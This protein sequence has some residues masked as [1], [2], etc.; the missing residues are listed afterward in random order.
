MLSIKGYVLEKPRVGTTNAAFTATP[1]N[2]VSDA[3]AYGT[4]YPPGETNPRT[5]YLVLVAQQGDLPT[6][7]FAWTKNEVIQRFDYSGNG[8]RFQTLPGGPPTQVGLIGPSVNTTRLKALLPPVLPTIEYPIRVA[9]TGVAAGVGL[10][11]TTVAT[12]TGFT[13]PSG[14][15][16]LSCQVSR[17]TGEFNFSADV[18][19]GYV[20][21]PVRYWRNQFFQYRES[22]G[23]I[24]V[25]GDFLLLNPIPGLGAGSSQQVPLVRIGFR[26]YL[27]A[28]SVADDASFGAAPSAGSFKWSIESGTIHL[29][30]ADLAAYAGD[31][32]YYD[33][34]CYQWGIPMPSDPAGTVGTVG[35]PIALT[36]MPS[37]GGDLIFRIPSIGYQF[38]ETVRVPVGM[39]DA[40]G[41]KGQVQTDKLGNIQFSLVDRTLYSA[42]QVEVIRGDLPIDHGI[43]LRLFRTPVDPGGTASDTRDVTALHG[44]QDSVLADPIIAS[45]TVIFPT[46][47]LDDGVLAVSVTQGT[48]SFTGTLPRLDVSS[49]PAGVGYIMDF[50]SRQLQFGFRRNLELFAVP[51]QTGSLQLSSGLVQT[52]V[53]LEY[54]T[55]TATNS[56]LP[57]VIGEDA[58]LDGPSG[59]LQWVESFGATREES[60]TGALTGVTFTDVE[61]DFVSASVQV[62]D[63][64][65]VQSAPSTGLY[66]VASIDSPTQVTVAATGVTGSSLIYKIHAGSDTLVD[67]FFR[68]LSVSDPSTKVE[69]IRGLRDSGGALKPTANS[70]RLS[71]KPSDA[72]RVRIRF[73]TARFSTLV[74]VVANDGLFTSPGSLL[75]GQVEVSLQTGNLNFSSADVT[76][77]EGVFSVLRLAE[78]EYKIRPQP[79]LIQ[80]TERLLGQDELLIGYTGQAGV[81]S[82]RAA[83]LVRKE[84]T[85]HPT[86]TTVV[87]FNPLGR[88][89]ATQPA[90]A[91]FRGG[92]PQRA[93]FCLVD[94][95]LSTIRFL[96]DG[97][98]TNVTAHGPTVSPQERIT[99][100]YYVY[101]ALGGENTLTVLSPPMVIQQ[102]IIVSGG[103]I[104]TLPGNRT[105]DLP[106]DFLFRFEG[107]EVYRITGSS[108]SAG[109]TTINVGSPFRTDAVGPR[110]YV[111]SG[112]CTTGAFF[113]LEAGIRY[114]VSRGMNVIPL[115]GDQ[116]VR[117]PQGTIVQFV[118]G[119]EDLYL[120]SGSTYDIGTDTTKVTLTSTVSR[121]YLPTVTMR[122]SVRPLYEEG[123]KIVSTSKAPATS[124]LIVFRAQT[125]QPGQIL[126][127][128]IDYTA[129]PSGRITLSQPLSSNEEVGA[130]YVGAR[131]ISAGPRVRA[132][133][134]SIIAPNGSNG[135]E[136]Q[137]LTANFNVYSPDTF[138]WR[139]ESMTKFRAEIASQFDQDVKSALPTTGPVTSN[140]S[141]PK[142]YQQG[143]ESLYF[144][145]G[146]LANEDIIGRAFLKYFNDN[147]N[148]LEDTLASIDGRV[149]GD[150]DG[151][152]RYDGL[153]GNTART[154]WAAVTN[155]IDDSI[156]ISDA[157]YQITFFPMVFTSVGTYV[158]AY[159]P[160]PLSRF[161]PTYKNRFGVTFA[162]VD[163]VAALGDPVLDTGSK[164][165]ILVDNLRRR[166]P[167][168]RITVKADAGATSLTVDNA[169]GSVDLLRPP[170]ENG[171]LVI[172]TGQ[173]GIPYVLDGSPLTVTS[174][175][176]TVLGVSALPVDIPAG[177]TV[178]LAPSDVTYTPFNFVVGTDVGYD[179]AKGLLTFKQTVTSGEFLQMGVTLVAPSPTPEKFP[180]LFG[181][182]TND[183][184]D[185]SVPMIGPSWEREITYLQQ[186]ADALTSISSSTTPSYV[187]TGNLNGAK[188]VISLTSGSF[189]SPAPQVYDLVRILDG[190]NGLTQ[191]RSVTAVTGS[192][193]TVSSPFAS[194]DSNFHFTVTVS[195]DLAS[196]AATFPTST[197]LQDLSADFVGAGVKVGHTAVVTSGGAAGQR[198]QITSVATT[199]LGLDAAVSPS[200]GANYRIAQSLATFSTIA[201]VTSVVTKEL[202]V[203]RDNDPL[204]IPGT[205]TSEKLSL[206]RFFEAVF[207][208]ILSPASQ[209]GTVSGNSL[210]GTSTFQTSGV[211]TNHY[212]YIRSGGSGGIYSVASVPSE[213]NLTTA[214]SFPVPG[215]VSYR[216]VSGFS[217]AK[218]SLVDL[219]CILQAVDVFI[220]ATVAFQVTTAAVIVATDGGAYASGLLSSGFGATIATRQTE[221]AARSTAVNDTSAGPIPKV[222]NVLGA[223]HLYDYRFTWISNR[224]HVEKGVLV[225]KDRETLA[226]LTKLEDQTAAV[227]KLAAMTPIDT[228]LTPEESTYQSSCP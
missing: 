23:A 4:A 174:V 94:T 36:N 52:N 55:G 185:V 216:V 158:S 39:F 29:S 47:P 71:I 140:G 97:T 105:A 167:R 33:G 171:M 117:Y 155:E 6:A 101:E 107:D 197:S 10:T 192:S 104:F 228:A 37:E 124:A 111:S 177:A 209:T 73:G 50:P 187:G 190:V 161:F 127:A 3:F 139:V 114:P 28:I 194:V 99:I 62:G 156:K 214:V 78:G 70:P 84:L 186:E 206:E 83:F 193:V 129:D 90:P 53:T 42:D 79:G 224:I 128:P 8:Q 212:V 227:V 150:S 25:V 100:D 141:S 159:Q 146:R 152:F 132:S 137:I 217:V 86:T 12:N 72:S 19:S 218:T 144:R 43:S 164:N 183:D 61:A 142:L 21:Q 172:I 112:P 69:K 82:E 17:S 131:T 198:R 85:V 48:G 160:S 87:P 189:P 30:S 74:T 211:G 203:L 179:Q 41:K 88:S 149:V 134:T 143:R 153:I 67:R 123:T 38:P 225:K 91:V 223:G 16:A 118:P 51:L 121:E 89:V 202:L 40:T 34:S 113:A 166:I 181:G 125:G 126:S 27:T 205:V 14:M 120:V 24:G 200:T 226:R 93:T 45:P 35:T 133:Y 77:A 191:Y 49:P 80:L 222:Q 182:T 57:L 11:V 180:A 162:G 110:L 145:A 13:T 116:V 207:T 103:S 15:S 130:F 221:L 136:G 44:A 26:Q 2:L 108:F 201:P 178:Y 109:T 22:S 75:L 219:Y 195:N 122:R 58:L 170:F 95:T 54:E 66:Q 135:L 151:R 106:V 1:D 208:D 196:G 215:S 184:G 168:G 213:T 154:S 199:L 92:R 81:V 63:W 65:D 148:L 98:L 18:V 220:A 138:Y 163:T 157:P 210:T 173:T 147:I 56:Y 5:D 119:A 115:A 20:G 46:T 96:E 32:V 165:L 102:A 9:V 68:P 60:T 31:V 7:T 175:A 188:T 204:S 59:V 176:S 169:T 64:V 76:L